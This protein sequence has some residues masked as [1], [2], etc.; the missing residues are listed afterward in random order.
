MRLSTEEK[1]YASLMKEYKMHLK[2]AVRP[3][4]PKIE[5]VYYS[6]MANN[7]L[8]RANSIPFK[9]KSVTKKESAGE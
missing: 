3:D 9:K 1:E 5:A 8:A 2:N 6:N 7:V 4:A